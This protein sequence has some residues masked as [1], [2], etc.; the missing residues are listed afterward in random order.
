M[1]PWNRYAPS[2]KMERYRIINHGCK[3]NRYDGELIRSELRRLGLVETP[4]QG[5]AD[6]VVLNACAVTDRAVQKGRQALRRLRREHPG[7]QVLLSGCMTG[8]DRAGYERIDPDLAVLRSGDQHQ[9]REAL[10]ELIG[11]AAPA[12]SGG[13]ATPKPNGGLFRDRT[14]AFLKVQD[15][16]DAHCSYCVIPSI[17]GGARS[18]P[19]QAVLEEAR[20]LIHE[21]FRELVLCGVHLGHYGKNTATKLTD[22]VLALSDLEG[23][24]RL[25]LSSLEIME[26]DQQL[27][28]ALSARGGIVPHLHLPLQSG[29]SSVLRAMRRPYDAERFL[30]KLQWI[31]SACPDLAVTTDVIVGFPGES[32]RDFSDTLDLVE[33]ARFAKVHIFPFSPR[34]GTEAA[35][36]P[37]RVAA[38]AVRRR[39]ALLSRLERR[40]RREAD[41][42]QMGRLATVLVERS[43]PKESSGLCE[44][45]RRI[46]LPGALQTS[47]FVR[48]RIV[49]RSGEDLIAEPC[50]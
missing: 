32:D 13:H 21:G 19:R 41:L 30:R 5:T 39:I 50:E 27:A 26:V 9:I 2:S 7:G 37:E 31:R 45:Y 25:R 47:T 35:K 34:I 8:D 36:L 1:Q 48:C 44:W 24:F 33:Q 28:D 23:E 49:D 4:A 22:L 38:P 18:R 12:I 11:H 14:R 42:E 3:V 16:C 46:R 20:M 10:L 29:S 17:R 40:L 43:T 15:G 6:L